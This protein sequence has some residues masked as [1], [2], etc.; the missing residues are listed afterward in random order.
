MGRHSRHGAS[1]WSSTLPR[2][3]GVSVRGRRGTLAAGLVA[4][5]GALCG[6]PAEAE[7]AR[8]A[9]GATAVQEGD[10]GITNLDFPI[11]RSGDTGAEVVVGFATVDGSASAGSDYT[12][13]S[14]TVTIAAGA[15]AAVVH[16][17]VLGDRIWERDE[18]V[19]LRLTGISAVNGP[20]MNFATR[21]SLRCGSSPH[22][23]LA[24]DL[25]GDGRC[26]L[27][28]VDS[29][30]STV[31]VLLNTT[32]PGAAVMT[33]APAVAFATGPAPVAVVAGDF[34]GD[35]RL[36][37]AVISQDLSG[38]TR[39]TL[40]VLFNTT[41]SGASVPAFTASAFD[42]HGLPLALAAGDFD[43]DGLT[44]LAV[45][46]S[47][48]V[49]VLQNLTVRGTTALALVARSIP[50]GTGPCALACAELTG[51]GRP[52][53]AVLGAG[54]PG[55]AGSGT[56]V[57][58]ANATPAGG[59]PTFI[60][61]G[62]AA[63][64]GG[65]VDLAAQDLTGDGLADLA[66]LVPGTSH[67]LVLRNLTPV[68]AATTA[69]GPVLTVP[70][71]AGAVAIATADLDGDGRAELITVNQTSNTIS[72]L[73]SL[74][75]AGGDPAF[76]ARSDY[77]VGAG[78]VAVATGLL[79]GDAR[80]DV[81]V[82]NFA[83][84][85][86]TLLPNVPATIATA[87]ALGTIR[88]DDPLPTVTLS[89]PQGGVL[90]EHGGQLGVQASLANPSSAA[91]TV[92]LAFGGAPAERYAASATTIVIP[93]G[94]LAGSVVVAAIDNSAHDGDAALA[95]TIAA[96]NGG[97]AAGAGVTLTIVDDDPAPVPI[98]VSLSAQGAPFSEH[99]G[100]ATVIATLSAPAATDVTVELVAGGVATA[101]W[102]LAP[103]T[104]IIPAGALAVSA[105]VTGVDDD[106][107]EGDQTLTVSIATVSGAQAAS[108]ASAVALVESDDEPVPVV[109]LAADTA[110]VDERGG[111][112]TLTATLS[113]AT[114][115]PV[116]MAL[117]VT[118][119]VATGRYVV[120]STQLTIPA[121][122]LAT[123]ATL[124]AVDDAI[125]DGDQGL[126]I[127]IGAVAGASVGAPAMV[128]VTIADDEAVP[129]VTLATDVATVAEAGGVA[130]LTAT[131]SGPTSVAVR[132]PLVADGGVAAGR[133]LLE[134]ALLTIPAGALSATTHLSGVDDALYEGDRVLHLALGAVVGAQMQP[135][136]T[137]LAITVG[138]DESVP[139]VALDVAGS[140]FA[141]NGGVATISAVLSG[142]C[143]DAVVV[144]LGFGGAAAPG[145]YATSGQ[146]II[147][148]A[149]ALSG[150]ITLTGR[151]D[152]V[153][154]GDQAVA[155]ALLSAPGVIS[156]GGGV[157]AILADDEPLPTA[158]LST[159]LAEIAEAGGVATLTVALSG[160]SS[161][162]VV[163]A[164]T[165]DD[166]VAAGRY[167]LA[168]TTLEIPAGALS[169]T[170]TLTAVDD[171]VYEGDR[172]LTIGIVIGTGA[173]ASPATA[174]VTVVDDETLPMVTLA[175]GAAAI[176]E[177]G[178]A[179]S[180]AATL[181]GPADAEVTVTLGFSGAE[182]RY[183]AGATRIVIPAGALGGG[184]A[185]TGHDDGLHQDDEVVVVTGLAASGAVVGGGAV[186][187]L[188]VDDEPQPTVTLALDASVLVE[189][190]GTA[191]LT[192]T[193]SVPAA[194]DVTVVIGALGVSVPASAPAAPGGADPD[195][196]A[197]PVTADPLADG[198]EPASAD[199]WQL[200][201]PL[202]VIPAG[203]LSAS[204]TLMAVD[205]QLF[206]GTEAL[207]LH[208][209]AVVGADDAMVEPLVAL[210]VDDDAP[211]LVA[212]AVDQAV[213]AEAGG[214]ATITATL[215][216]P[217]GRAV[218]VSLAAGAAQ[219]LLTAPVIVIPAGLLA[220]SVQLAAQDDGLA[221]GDQLVAVAIVGV[222]HALP[223]D[224]SQVGV[225]ITDAGMPVL[226][227]TA[228]DAFVTAGAATT[229]TV[230]LDRAAVRDVNVVLASSGSADPADYA[231]AVVVLVIPAG[232]LEAT[233]V[234]STVADGTLTGDATVVIAAT[235]D[236]AVSD[237]DA[238]VVVVIEPELPPVPVGD[239]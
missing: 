133:Y 123:T 62:G 89:L 72:V 182:G 180:L 48:Q 96:V 232:A 11:T 51:D 157:V 206:E 129:F 141:E 238:A 111:V 178:G 148:P 80:T 155:I 200:S 53:L 213:I 193:L 174:V 26:D 239:S 216:A 3:S 237:P 145:R 189:A 90:P 198:A 110:T 138:D 38:G 218:T 115:V 17:P 224:P 150:S 22:A 196:T 23:V 202:I 181:S 168:T 149:G 45:V 132:V 119:G 164:L 147:I 201:A 187:I 136:A 170:T 27:V 177:N 151:D 113:T 114:T 125:H 20:G 98:Q 130:Q 179:T 134:D 124:T 49:Q 71:R 116:Q 6:P 203:A 108:G 210:I 30:D 33:S 32:V 97:T 236:F 103:S 106:V 55:V 74:G 81:A 118:A 191:T 122:A 137:P 21:Q 54:T 56:V 50:V 91:V 143:A 126:T 44:D 5:L 24:R 78:P 220:G 190:G 233:I 68:G 167:A 105:T 223:G 195:V 107:H 82:A 140:P 235:A 102:R 209:A 229:L 16:V 63:M 127:G 59:T 109:T 204:V 76:A 162:P 131:L 34:N 64:E 117:T 183:D 1:R 112:A 4:L 211:P 2:A 18:T 77:A 175:A 169:A 61:A 139:T 135:D 217:C 144:T 31:T 101:R 188:I 225:A 153:H 65:C 186:G 226:S 234:L 176:A 128:T 205:D 121:G 93:A 171:A 215:S 194:T 36:D 166:G 84:T 46:V 15:T 67:A 52:D 39:A 43:Q 35:G 158:I 199:D 73:R 227:L 83:G 14:G 230:R 208:I 58:L 104:V 9:V 185:L 37:L 231:L 10:S 92:T 142:P 60:A 214:V 222:Q 120:S 40:T 207:A 86:L 154:Q 19:Q 41:P 13:T 219:G 12:A 197:A 88:N 57:V 29:D 85:T 212:L 25:N 146:Q 228:A 173:V 7:D 160:A 165:T 221:D 42:L 8:I 156:L 192:A 172:A 75:V 184:I 99:G 161:T 163:V 152:T 66:V 100:A 159:D 47:G 87:V 69:F 95:V 70:I 28:S 94:A 79:T